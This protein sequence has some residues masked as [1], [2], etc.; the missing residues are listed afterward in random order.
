[1]AVKRRV[2]RLGPSLTYQCIEPWRTWRKTFR[3]PARLVSGDELRSGGV[4]DGLHVKLSFD[5]TYEAMCPPFELG[6]MH[7]Q[8]WASSHYEQHCSV[9]GTLSYGD[10]SVEVA[11]TGLR[12]HSTGVR[13]LTGLHNHIWCHAEWPDGRAFCLMYLANSDG[14]GRMNHA[15]V[16]DENGVRPGKLVSAAP[17]L[18][19]WEQRGDDY[20]L[21]LEVEDEKIELTAT[22]GEVGALSIAGPGEIVRGAARGA[23]CASLALRSD[24]P[25]QLGWRRGARP[26]RTIGPGAMSLRQLPQSADGLDDSWASQALGASVRVADR[27]SVGL[28]IAFACRLFRL[29]LDGPPGMPGSVLVKMPIEGDTR[30]MLDGIGTYSREIQFYREVAP[31]LPVRTPKI[32]SAEQAT[33]STDF[34]LV[35]EDLSGECVQIDQHEGFSQQQAKAVVDAVARFHSWSWAKRGS[36]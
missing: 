11:G 31:H 5:L 7:E 15:V 20:T 16:C 30:A 19:S 28:G 4:A 1:M 21:T 10:V 33:D 36:A 29:M 17:L 27:E 22:L 9:T 18:D 26:I 23:G 6:A 13:D 24:D 32:Y 2:G 34:L 14:S 12:D 35:M 3:G 25:V 8:N